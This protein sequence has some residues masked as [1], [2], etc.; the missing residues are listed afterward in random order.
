MKSSIT[1]CSTGK[2]G[3]HLHHRGDEFHAA[4]FAWHCYFGGY[5]MG[6]GGMPLQDVVGI[7]CKKDSTTES[8]GSGVKYMG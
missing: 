6:R 5:H 7:N 2:S 8:H 1:A 3:N 4:I